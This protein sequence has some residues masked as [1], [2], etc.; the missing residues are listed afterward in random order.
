[1]HCYCNSKMQLLFLFLFK[2]LHSQFELL[3]QSFAEISVYFLFANDIH[4]REE[5]GPTLMLTRFKAVSVSGCAVFLLFF[6]LP[7]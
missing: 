7:S 5:R 1:M 6:L 4:Q 3:R 2:S